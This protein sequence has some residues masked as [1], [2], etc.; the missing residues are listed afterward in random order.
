VSVFFY[1]FFV[2]GVNFHT[3]NFV[4]GVN[5]HT[6]NFVNGVYIFMLCTHMYIEQID[7]I[8]PVFIECSKVLFY[9]HNNGIMYIYVHICTKVIYITT[10]IY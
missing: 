5:F 6:I 2:N 1:F 9:V 3:I 10:N 4:N 8:I 7:C